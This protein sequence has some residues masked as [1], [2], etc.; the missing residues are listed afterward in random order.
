VINRVIATA[1]DAGPPG[2]DF[3]YGYGYIDANAAVSATVPEVAENPM[4]DLAE[5][6]RL[7]RRAETSEPPVV[8]VAPEPEAVPEGEFTDPTGVLL[9]RMVTLQLVGAP[10]LVIVILTLAAT[11]FAVAAVRRIRARSSR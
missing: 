11:A 10:L 3:S 5:W 8:V 6:V 1:R 7:H 9:P 4:G 2:D